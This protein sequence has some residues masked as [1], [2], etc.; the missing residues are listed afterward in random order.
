MVYNRGQRA[1]FDN[2]AQR[3]NRGWGYVDILPY[4]KR[5]ERRIGGDDTPFHGRD[6]AI[7][8]TD[9]DWIHPLSE[10]FIAGAVGTGI[11][12]NPDYNGAGQEGVGYFQRAIHN[13]W[14]RSAARMFLHPAR[15]RGN[16]DVRT[17]ARAAAV[18][19]DGTRATGVRYVHD[20]DRTSHVV[21]ARRE[22]IVSS[23]TANTAKLL[24]M[25]GIG[26]AALLQSIGAPVLHA[27]PGVGENFRDHYS[28][29]LV[30]RVKGARTMNED[31]SG[32]GLVAQIARWAMGKPSILALVP[33]NVFWFTRTQD[34]LQDPDLQGVFTPASYKAGFVGL[35][36]DFPGMTVGV[37]QHRPDSVGYVRARSL[38]PFQ[39]AG[40]RPAGAAGRPAPGARAA[41][42]HPAGT[43]FRPRGTARRR[44]ADRR[45]N[46]GLCPALWF[47]RIPSD[48]H[49]ADGTGQRP[50]GGGR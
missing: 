38:D 9:M 3:G 41:A 7:P 13:G 33:S 48:R 26:P 49:R 2:W 17:H 35:L 25:S 28:V 37:W 4:F 21:H 5:S 20:R 10:A 22:V 15:R 6:G 40:I 45:R 24:Q 19:L 1:D 27:L 36:D 47:H 44:G 42:H 50:D 8:V 31:G 32:L 34:T 12:R 23:G 16:L 46:A 43:V 30:A 14:R 29:R 39:D 11:P 18:L